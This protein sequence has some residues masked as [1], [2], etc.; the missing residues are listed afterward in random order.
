ML[1]SQLVHFAG[2][3]QRVP[4]ENEA[5]HV[6]ESCCSN[7]RSDSSAQ[8]LAAN[9][10]RATADFFLASCLDDG[11]ETRFELIVRIRDVPPFFGIEKIESSYSDSTRRERGGKFPHEAACLIGARS[12]PQNQCDIGEVRLGR[13]VDEG[14]HFLI[15]GDFD[16]HFFRHNA[17]SLPIKVA[18]LLLTD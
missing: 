16:A 18:L 3:M 2:R 12:M 9:H 10:Q 14:S 7:L 15:W 5:F 1:C 13:R 11:P 8:R 4:K 6:G 17:P